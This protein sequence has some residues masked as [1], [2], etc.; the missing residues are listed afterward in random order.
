MYSLYLCQDCIAPL[1]QPL[2]LIF[3]SSYIFPFPL[4]TH[5]YYLVSDRINMWMNGWMDDQIQSIQCCQTEKSE[6]IFVHRMWNVYKMQKKLKHTPPPI[7]F[8]LRRLDGS[9]DF[10]SYISELH[11]YPLKMRIKILTEIGK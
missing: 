9:H 10:P 11:F 3:F 2:Y 1:S 6:A 4:L 7:T 8:A 5:I